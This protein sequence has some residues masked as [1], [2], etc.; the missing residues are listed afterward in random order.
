[1][2]KGFIGDFIDFDVEFMIVLS[3]PNGPYEKNWTSDIF[4]ESDGTLWAENYN[5]SVNQIQ[6]WQEIRNG[7]I[8]YVY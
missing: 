2:N 1:M 3:G 5:S 7:K 6:V 8:I 4:G